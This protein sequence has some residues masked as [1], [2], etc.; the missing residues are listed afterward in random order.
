VSVI[1]SVLNT[2]FGWVYWRRGVSVIGSVEY[3]LWL[4]ILETWCERDRVS[5]SVLNTCFGWVYWSR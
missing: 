5:A 4:G 1:G 2:C 3:M